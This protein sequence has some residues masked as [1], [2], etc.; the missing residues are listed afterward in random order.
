[1][2]ASQ[3]IAFVMKEK[4]WPLEKAKKYVH[5]KRS[6]I[7]P[8]PGFKLQLATYEGILDARFVSDHS[9]PL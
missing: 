7:Q 8:N 5:E 4:G 2:S 9:S 1:M 6:C 3:V